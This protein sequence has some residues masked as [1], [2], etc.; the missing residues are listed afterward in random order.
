MMD[1]ESCA[2]RQALWKIESV[3]DDARPSLEPLPP[4][5]GGSWPD[6]AMVK[7][8]LCDPCARER[9]IDNPSWSRCKGRVD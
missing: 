3:R 1:C 5:G 8:T 9:L 6:A 7:E 2:S 4:T